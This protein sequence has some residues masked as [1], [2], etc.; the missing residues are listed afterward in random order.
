MHHIVSAFCVLR[1]GSNLGTVLE[2]ESQ[3]KVVAIDPSKP[4]SVDYRR[5]LK[6]ESLTS[7]MTFVAE[8]NVGE[9]VAVC[10]L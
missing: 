9:Q 6:L 1:K 7:S 2:L 5:V 8:T 3:I 10:C 4:S